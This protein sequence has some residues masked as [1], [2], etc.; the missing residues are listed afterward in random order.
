MSAPGHFV[1]NGTSVPPHYDDSHHRLTWSGSPAPKN[2]VTI[3]YVVTVTTDISMALVNTAE[4]H[5]AGGSASTAQAVAIANPFQ[6]YMPLVLKG[7]SR[8][9]EVR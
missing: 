6:I 1:L 4:L 8:Q 7:S 3:G 9:A 5:E 2:E